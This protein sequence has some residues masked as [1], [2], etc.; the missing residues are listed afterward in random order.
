[1]TLK[2]RSRSASL[3]SS[4]GRHRAPNIEWLYAVRADFCCDKWWT[5]ISNAICTT[6][7]YRGSSKLMSLIKNKQY[8]ISLC[9]MTMFKS[10]H[11]TVDIPKITTA[12]SELN[13]I[14]AHRQNLALCE[15]QPENR[16]FK[17]NTTSTAWPA[18]TN[19]AFLYINLTQNI[20]HLISN[21][22]SRLHNMKCL[23]Y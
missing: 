8:F 14:P 18:A 16:H 5:H 23:C 7:S 17:I 12:S 20:S 3:Y 21:S 19:F 15:C 1:M 2:N 6:L 22:L 4:N 13:T 11:S 9:L 10:K